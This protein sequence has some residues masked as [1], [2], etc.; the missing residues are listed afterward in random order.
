[1]AKALLV[2]PSYF[3]L[4]IFLI[5]SSV[6]ISVFG[7]EYSYVKSINLE[8]MNILKEKVT[9]FQLYWQDVVSGSDATSITVIEAVN[10]SST[11]FG[12]VTIIDDSLTVEP[13]L[14]SKTVG[15]SQGFYASTGQEEFSLLMVMNFA[16]TDGKYNGSTFTVVGRNNVKAKVREMSIV[17]GSGLFRF[18]RG[19]VLASTYSVSDNGD[20]TV[21]YNCYVIHY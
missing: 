9:H 12:S 1:M 17:S 13:N 11:L 5:F 21:E 10:N 19:Y 2:S 4:F 16:F 8:K 6:K 14:S 18:A 3:I 20:A 15:K 7:E